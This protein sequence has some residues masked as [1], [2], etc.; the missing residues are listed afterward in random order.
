M[1]GLGGIYAE[2]FKDVTFRVLAI[3]RE[4]VKEMI[5]SLKGQEYAQGFQRL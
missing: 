2:I 4:D 1:F 3:T 5:E